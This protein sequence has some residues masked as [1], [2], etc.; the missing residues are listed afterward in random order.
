[1]PGLGV[2]GVTEILECRPAVLG[3]WP[4]PDPRTGISGDRRGGRCA[5]W[6]PRT[7]AVQSATSGPACTAPCPEG[8]EQS[9]MRRTPTGINRALGLIRHCD[10]SSTEPRRRTL[11]GR[12]RGCDACTPDPRLGASGGQGSSPFLKRLQHARSIV[13]SFS[14]PAKLL[15]AVAAAVSM[16]GALALTGASSASAAGLADRQS[17]PLRTG[18]EKPRRGGWSAASITGTVG[19]EAASPVRRGLVVE[20][21]IKHNRD[22]EDAHEDRD[23]GQHAPLPAH[24]RRLLPVLPSI[25]GATVGRAAWMRPLCECS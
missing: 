4:V 3:H 23:G 25:H 18:S 8:G 11:E 17:G 22:D 9:C 19:T 12:R 2:S 10:S 7:S 1:M 14:S 13:K 24:L 20:Q 15:F 16:A 21:Q 6:L 5:A